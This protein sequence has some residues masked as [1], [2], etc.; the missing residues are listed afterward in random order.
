MFSDVSEEELIEA[1]QGVENMERFLKPLNKAELDNLVKKGLSKK[2]EQKTKWA[3][4]LFRKWQE[5]RRNKSTDAENF[6]SNKNIFEMSDEEL[7]NTLEYFV[8]E[9]RNQK[10]EDYM[11]NTIYEFVCCIQHHET[12][13]KICEVFF[14][15]KH[16]MDLKK[17]SIK[18]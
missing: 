12:N 11:P 17:C 9:V 1:S 6:I 15:T 16:F 2:T 18:K 7:N 10:G 4:Y 8:A 5:D 13:G 3:I 14:M